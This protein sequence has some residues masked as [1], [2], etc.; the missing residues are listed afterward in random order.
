VVLRKLRKD[1]ELFW[2]DLNIARSSVG[3][4]CPVTNSGDLV[5]TLIGSGRALHL[6]LVAEGV[7]SLSQQN[8]LRQ[9]GC[10]EIQDKLF[11]EPM[12]EADLRPPLDAD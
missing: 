6:P 5:R 10:D 3:C 12:S 8:F 4:I 2:N 9:N 11:H 7:E 1:G